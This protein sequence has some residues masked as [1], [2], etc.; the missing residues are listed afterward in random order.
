MTAGKTGGAGAASLEFRHVSKRYD[1]STARG[2][3]NDLSFEVPAGAICVLVGPSGCGKT[4]SL[5]MVNRLIE[6]SA[7][8]ILLENVNRSDG[9]LH[10]ANRPTK[11]AGVAGP[12]RTGHP[13]PD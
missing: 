10:G 11:M 12:A 2:A 5:K 7:G 13:E 1:N 6:P 9:H 4:T 3:V 8:L